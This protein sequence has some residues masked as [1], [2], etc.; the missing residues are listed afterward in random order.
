LPYLKTKDYYILLDTGSS[1][2]LISKTYVYKNKRKFE[3]FK[4]NFEFNTA[5]GKTSGKEYI[6][7][8]IEKIPIKCYLFDFHVNFNV[9]IGN[10][11]L[12]QLNLVWNVGEDLIKIKEKTIKINY[13]KNDGCQNETNKMEI[14]RIE[15]RTNHV[16][17]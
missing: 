6:I 16:N 12:K 14:Q 17:R 10:P 3:I 2:N 1:I 7:L 9:L 11:T 13:F 5:T 4:E 8:R 15:I